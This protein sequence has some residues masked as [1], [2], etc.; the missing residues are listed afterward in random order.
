MFSEHHDFAHGFAKFTLL[1]V[2]H[3]HV[4]RADQVFV[5]GTLVLRPF[6]CQTPVKAFGDKACTAT[7]DVHDLAHQ[8]CVDPGHVVIEVQVQI[9][10]RGSKFGGKVVAQ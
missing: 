7:G 3:D 9:H 5:V 10:H 4:T 8:V 6:G 1:V 2:V